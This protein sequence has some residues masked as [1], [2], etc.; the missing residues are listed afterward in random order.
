MSTTEELRLQR[1]C[2]E[3]P[4][5]RVAKWHLEQIGRTEG[6]G[7]EAASLRADHADV[8]T[9]FAAAAVEAR[10][11]AFI[12]SPLLYMREEGPRRFLAELVTEYY[13]LRLPQKVRFLRNRQ[14]ALKKHPL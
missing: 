8:V 10:L 12:P 6:A 4:L 3:D 14:E 7:H 11:N 2:D 1:L 9:V 13:Q 5:L